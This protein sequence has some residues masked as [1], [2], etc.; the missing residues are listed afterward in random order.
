MELVDSHCHLHDREFF[1]EEQAEEMLG[2]AHARGVSRIICIGTSHNDSLAARGFC[3]KHAGAFWTYGVH[4]EGAGEEYEFT[5]GKRLVGIGEV[6][7]DYHYPGYNREKQIR[8]LEEMIQLAVEHNLP[9]SFHVRDALPDFFDV[10]KN[11]PKLKPSVLHSFSDSRE[12]LERALE[13]G[14]YIGVNGIATFANL[15]CYKELTPDFLEKAVLE[16]DAPFLTPVPNR[17][18]IN[19][20]GNVFDVAAWLAKKFNVSVAEV[21]ERTTKNAKEVFDLPDSES[22]R[23]RESDAGF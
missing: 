13:F 5:D 17:G 23:R 22:A 1:A 10:V 2:R 16:T 20:P 3:E 14:F 15:E 18:K 8:L 9:C 6:G 19:E 4:P 21:A 11:F 12:N 7:L